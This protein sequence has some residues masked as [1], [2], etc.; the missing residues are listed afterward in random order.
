MTW[1]INMEADSQ[2]Y[3]QFQYPGGEWQIRFKPKW[4]DW[5]D[6]HI[7]IVCR[8]MKND[9]LMRMAL[10]VS[11]IRGVRPNCDIDLVLPYLPYARADRKFTAGDC[12][13][14]ATF[15][16]IVNGL[17]FSRV[18]TLDA[19]SIASEYYIERLADIPAI[20][21]IH[22][23][24]G[25]FAAHCGAAGMTVLFPDEG[26]RKRYEVEPNI[27]PMR[28]QVLNCQKKRDPVTGKLLGFDVP[29][30][31]TRDAIIVDDICDGGGTFLGIAS[32]LPDVRLGLYVTHGI[33]SQGFEGLKKHFEII[34]TTDSFQNVSSLDASVADS[35][36]AILKGEAVQAYA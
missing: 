12:H 25:Q 4:T 6:S 9:G 3:E 35:L 27:G 17:R 7:R 18:F 33:F 20:P 34:Y 13:G 22:R 30:V 14:L 32:K 8:E 15:G 36:A 5:G 24:I 23:A 29:I 28:L 19:H 1:T 21:L 10:L 16:A 11:A 2:F 26:A 31:K